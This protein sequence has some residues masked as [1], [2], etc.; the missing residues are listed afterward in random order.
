M[1]PDRRLVAEAREGLALAGVGD[2]LQDKQDYR[3]A[4]DG[5]PAAMPRLLLSHN[6][7]V[8]EEAGLVR[9]GLRVDLMLSGHTHGGQLPYLPTVRSRYGQKYVRGLVQGPVCPVFVCRG[10][11]MVRLP[12]RLRVPPEIA[13]IELR[14]APASAEG[15]NP[16]LSSCLV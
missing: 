1:T 14:A 11:G 5:L 16:C 10:I 8:A 3:Q 2:L 15:Q 9:S 4:L 13:V 7:D 6:P 12:L